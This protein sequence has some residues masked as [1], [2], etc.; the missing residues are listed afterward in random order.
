MRLLGEY[1]GDHNAVEA[2]GHFLDAL[3]LE[4]DHRQP[5][6]EFVGR[7]VKV[8]VL[9]EPVVGYFHSEG[10]PAKT[11]TPHGKQNPVKCD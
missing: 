9:L 10:E 2:A 6:G 11:G 5:L 1:L 8:N 4:A 7:P 3:D